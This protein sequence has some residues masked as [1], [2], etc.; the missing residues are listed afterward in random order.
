M[1]RVQWLSASGWAVVTVWL[2]AVPRTSFDLVLA[3]YSLAF[4]LYMLLVGGP[5]PVPLS[6]GLALALAVR[7]AGFFFMPLWS[8]D[9]YRFVWDGMLSFHGINPMAHTPEEIMAGATAFTGD[10]GLFARL[11][12]TA[13]HS[14]YP[15]VAQAVYWAGY[16]IA[17]ANL[18]G[19][20]LFMKSVLIAADAGVCFI[21][22]RLLSIL[23]RDRREVLWY[24]LSPL[25]IIELSGNLHFEGVMLLGLLAACLA[26]LT[27]RRSYA[28][29]AMAGSVLSKMV[30]FIL[31]PFLPGTMDG[32]RVIPAMLAI[33]AIAVS[34]FWIAFGGS[35]HWMDSIGLWFRKF[36]FTAGP[37]YLVRWLGYKVTG[38]NAI[39]RIGPA[40][41][42][43]TLIGLILIWLWHRFGRGLTWMTAMAFAL[44]LHFLMGTTIHPWYLTTLLAVG[45][46]AGLRYP[47]A[48]TY[49]AVFSYSH[50]AGGG[51]REHYGWIALE[52]IG[53]VA[54]MAAEWWSSRKK[55]EP[56]PTARAPTYSSL[57]M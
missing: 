27:G 35:L 47:V 23:G 19:H 31:A 2:F 54:F 28:I 49:L 32:R 12:H 15:P 3:V 6:V 34:G 20:V 55:K 26:G 13:Y 4:G 37:Y 11:N 7:V 40:M 50:Y 14:V 10:A 51:F 22:M 8:D 48:W 16:G 24:A 38:Y 43:L 39:H 9:Y 46:L 18:T 56:L 52:Y 57:S 1:T 33:T 53:L 29:L 25:V 44:T 21:L 42:A 30:T 36:E 5:R 41:A 45:M 17:G